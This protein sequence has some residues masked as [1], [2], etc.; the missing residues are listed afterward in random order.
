MATPAFVSSAQRAAQRNLQR[1][2]PGAL[3]ASC[4]GSAVVSAGFTSC[5]FA[6]RDPTDKVVKRFK[7]INESN[8]MRRWLIMQHP[9]ANVLYDFDDSEFMSG[10]WRQNAN[11]A[12]NGAIDGEIEIR[13]ST[14]ITDP[15]VI[16]PEKVEKVVE[17]LVK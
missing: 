5:F 2:S 11:A 8:D 16:F 10:L 6:A 12:A 14:K 15:I 13:F 7:R 17:D 3:I 9:K 1:Y 4:I